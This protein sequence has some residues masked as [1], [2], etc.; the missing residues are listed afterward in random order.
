M[1]LGFPFVFVLLRKRWS[2]KLGEERVEVMP[3][4]QLL[5]HLSHSCTSSCWPPTISPTLSPL[6]SFWLK[7]PHPY[8][9]TGPD[10]EHALGRSPWAAW[11]IGLDSFHHLLFSS[12]SF[13]SSFPRPVVR[14]TVAK[15][16]TEIGA[17]YLTSLNWSLF[18]SLVVPYQIMSVFPKTFSFV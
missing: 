10:P 17:K 3:P 12:L 6:L 4:W 2:A 13:F 14:Q 5:H 7:K 15:V 18:N 16:V 11:M 8:S 9:H 1:L